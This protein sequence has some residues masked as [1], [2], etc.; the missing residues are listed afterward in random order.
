MCAPPHVSV[1]FCILYFVWVF[2]FLV[3]GLA[4]NSQDIIVFQIELGFNNF[5]IGTHDNLEP[6]LTFNP[7]LQRTSL[8]LFIN[9]VT[10]LGGVARGVSA[11]PKGQ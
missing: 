5:M 1:M 2:T 9:Y 4:L 7:T 10:Q 6:N 8:G 3:L 11:E